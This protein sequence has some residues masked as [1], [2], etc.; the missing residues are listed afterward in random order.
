M[1]VT[2]GNYAEKRYI[3]RVWRNLLYALA[4]KRQPD[5]FGVQPVSTMPQERKCPVEIATAH[6]DSVTRFVER[7]YWCQDNVEHSRRHNFAILRFENSELGGAKLGIRRNFLEPH[8]EIIFDHGSKNALFLPPCARKN[9]PRVH[10]V[11]H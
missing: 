9:F 6:T 3:P 2:V 7:D 1:S 11:I 8:A 5:E 10:F 4:G